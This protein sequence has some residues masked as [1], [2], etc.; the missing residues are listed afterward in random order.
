MLHAI[1]STMEK[2]VMA[3]LGSQASNSNGSSNGSTLIDTTI[4]HPTV[5][6]S[7]FTASNKAQKIILKQAAALKCDEFHNKS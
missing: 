4:L 6:N 1:D 5:L 2:M 3:D 7:A